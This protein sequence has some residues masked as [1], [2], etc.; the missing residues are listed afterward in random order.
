VN[1]L[2]C[3]SCDSDNMNEKKSC[4]KKERRE[5]MSCVDDLGTSC[6]TKVQDLQ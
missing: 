2:E 6:P 5:S 3:A 4:E 1:F